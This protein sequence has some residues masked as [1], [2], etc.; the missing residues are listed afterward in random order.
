MGWSTAAYASGAEPPKVDTG[1][2]TFVLLS[3]ALVMLMTPGL[4]LF[5]GG[6]VRRKNALAT[7]M[8]SFICLGL[9]GVAWVVYGYSLAFGPDKGGV[10]GGLEWLGLRG[11]GLDPNPDYAATIPHQAFMIYQAMFAVITP[12]LITGAFAERM[13]FKSFVF[14]VLLWF[15]LVYLP[16]A[17]WVWGVGGWLRNLGALD[18]A[19]GTVVHITSGVSAL[20]AAI[21]MGRRLR[22]MSG[23]IRLALSKSADC[24]TPMR[25][26]IPDPLPSARG[27]SAQKQQAQARRFEG[28]GT[29]GTAARLHR[30]DVGRGDLHR[31]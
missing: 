24:L 21:V 23:E 12:A 19:G 10:I 5:Y 26:T 1:D 20:V 2:T 4:A 13:K 9:V 16:V 6:M 11:V 27:G 22:S 18:F 7:I 25:S 14:F 3:A 15:T 29:E 31:D 28:P 30:D 17:H 8:Q